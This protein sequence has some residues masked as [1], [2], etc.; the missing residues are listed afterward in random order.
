MGRLAR[1]VDASKFCQGTSIVHETEVVECT[2]DSTCVRPT[3]FH[4]K[5]FRPCERDGCDLCPSGPDW[6]H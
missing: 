3:S 5:G 1:G 6:A 4:P 2:L